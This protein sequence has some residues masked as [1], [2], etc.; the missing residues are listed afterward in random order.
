MFAHYQFSAAIM[1]SRIKLDLSDI[2]KALLDVDDA[3]LS[4]DDLR[5]ISKQ[6]PTSEEVGIQSSCKYLTLKRAFFR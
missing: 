3:K 1:L 2:R 6:L 4:M 5:S